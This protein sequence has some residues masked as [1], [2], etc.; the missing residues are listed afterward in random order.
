MVA[1]QTQRDTALSPGDSNV[2]IRLPLSEKC[3]PMV[4]RLEYRVSPL[5]RN[6][7]ALVPFSGR[8]NSRVDGQTHLPTG[9]NHVHFLSRAA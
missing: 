5:S 2:S 9:T 7:T 6:Y 1:F 4:E 8:L 3:N